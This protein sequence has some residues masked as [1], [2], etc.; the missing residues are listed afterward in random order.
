MSASETPKFWLV[1]PASV[2]PLGWNS[3]FISKVSQKGNRRRGS[4]SMVALPTNETIEIGPGNFKLSFSSVSGQLKRISNSKTGVDVP[5]QQS[6]LWYSSSQGDSDPQC[7]G[8][9]IFRPNG[10]PPSVVS[11]S[12]TLKIVRGP[13]VD[14]V[15][16]Q[17]ASWIYQVI[18]VYRDKDHAE[19]EYTIGPIPTDDSVGKEVITRMTGNMVT[20]KLF[21]TDSNGRDFLKRVGTISTNGEREIGEL[22]AKAMGKLGTEGVS[23]IQEGKTLFNE[24]EVG[25]GMKLDRGYIS[26]YFVT[27]QKNQ[28]CEMDDALILIHE[29]KISSLNGIVKVLA[30]AL[31]RQ[32]PLLI[33]AEDVESEALATLIL[34]KISTGIRVCAIKAPGFGENKKSGLQDLAVPTGGQV[35]TEE[36][37]LYLDEVNLDMLGSLSTAD[38][39]KEKLQGRLA[40]LSGGG[41][42]SLSEGFFVIINNLWELRNECIE[43]SF[44]N[45]VR[46][47]RADWPLIVTQPVAGNYYPIN[48]GIYM[49]DQKAEF[50]VLVDRASGGSSINDGEIELMLHRRIL[51]DDSRGVGEPLDETVC[52]NNTCEG[53]TVRGNYYIGVN[54]LGA[55]ARWRRTTGQEIYSPLLLAFSHE[56]SE[57]W[58]SSHLTTATTMDANYSLPLNVALI[59]LQD[60]VD[61]SVLLRLAHLYE[62]GEDPDNSTL[63]KVELKR[64]FAGKKIKT[65]KETS[66]SGNQIKSEIK[67]MTWE[68]KP[69]VGA[70]AAAAP[71]RGG[72]V[73]I[74]SL[75]VELGPM[76]YLHRIKVGNAYDGPN[77][78]KNHEP[79][80]PDAEQ[81]V[82]SEGEKLSATEADSGTTSSR[83]QSYPSSTVGPIPT[84][85]VLPVKI[86]YHT[87]TTDMINQIKLRIV[88]SL[89]Y[90]NFPGGHPFQY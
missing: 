69:E 33:V 68:V 17:F 71:I 12:V 81:K 90:E 48:L 79:T 66:L 38:D 45:N 47:Y 86:C 59:T 13:L 58:K 7:S 29:K 85:I 27:N 56:N 70:G 49:E 88:S 65:L 23:T 74:S 62:A 61:G 15:H 4:M 41:A 10:M 6:Y 67:R 89:T 46:D 36:L 60:L 1:F 34:N 53:L 51:N 25:E 31:E 54:E 20:N 3:Y 37:G 64:M 78:R 83:D 28:K 55:G 8:A 22:I 72:P 35:L 44:D 11:R 87:F 30:L 21:Y 73:D 80:C 32:R 5:V 19:V 50:S 42:A 24:L 57:Y 9:Y 76:E 43:Q 2:P 26:P 18:R 63:A 39:D 77:Y 52:A 82:L 40:K 16:Q 75:T 84:Y 14:E